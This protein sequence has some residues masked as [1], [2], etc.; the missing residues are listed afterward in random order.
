MINLKNEKW[1]IDK[2]KNYKSIFFYALLL[3]LT[4]T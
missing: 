3:T 1:K 4:L 2:N